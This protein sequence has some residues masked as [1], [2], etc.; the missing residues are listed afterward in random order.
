MTEGASGPAAERG[1]VVGIFGATE[2]A[3]QYPARRQTVLALFGAVALDLRDAQLPPDN[4]QLRVY[5]L[6]GGV[7]IELPEGPRVETAGFS[8]F[9]ARSVQGGKRSSH[10][11]AFVRLRAVALFGGVTVKVTSDPRR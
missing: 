6:F 4:F 5:A 3:R 7:K 8:L 1:P 9:G 10:D 2:Q 11:G